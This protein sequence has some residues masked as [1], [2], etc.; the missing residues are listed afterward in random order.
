MNLGALFCVRVFFEVAS[1]MPRANA[2][3][4]RGRY[5]NAPPQK[6]VVQICTGKKRARA[7]KTHLKEGAAPMYAP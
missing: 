7:L 4:Q 6:T 3:P 5:V 1:P 2:P